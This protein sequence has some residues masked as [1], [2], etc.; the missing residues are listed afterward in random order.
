LPGRQIGRSCG[1]GTRAG[2]F[3]LT[4]G[5]AV[6]VERT[7]GSDRRRVGSGLLRGWTPD[8]RLVLFTG[9]NRDFAEGTFMTRNLRS[10]RT[11]PVL[12]S[13][14]VSAFAHR[15]AQLGAL[16][17]S[18]DGRY[19]AA[20]VILRARGAGLWGVIIAR[21]NGRLVRIL[22]S[23][24]AISMLAWSPRRHELA[25]TTSG[26][27]IPHE[28]YVVSSPQARSRRILSQVP[29]FDWVTWSPDGRWLLI[30]NEHRN[31]WQLL[32][33]TGDREARFLG[34]ASV[35]SRLLTRFGGMPLWCCPQ[36]NYAGS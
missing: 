2:L 23:K 22:T 3:C 1:P 6:F 10:G 26:F 14:Q 34:G 15:P 35:P 5:R 27:P 8:G 4:P 7:D 24:D 25:Y 28:L 33:I 29:H 13:R 20:R 19:V 12:S 11:H 21:A 31:A 30:D 17:Y 32:R 9:P 18:A 36:Q 16:A